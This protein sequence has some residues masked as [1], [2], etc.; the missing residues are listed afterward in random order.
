MLQMGWKFIL[1]ASMASIVRCSMNNLPQF[2]PDEKTIDCTDG[3]SVTQIC[4]IKFVIEPLTSMTYYKLS[5]DFRELRGYRATFSSAGKL[6][7]LRSGLD[8]TNLR[9]PILTDGHF[10]PIITINAQMPGP[11]IIAHEGQTLNITVYNELKNVE[12]VSIHWHGMHQRGTQGAD[13]VAYITQRPIP[14]HHKFTYTFKA[15]PAGTH[16]YHAHSGAQRTDGMYGALIVKDIIPNKYEHDLPDQHTLILMDWQKDAS[17]DLFYPIGTSLSYWKEPLHDQPYIRYNVTRGP[18]GTE[19]GQ[20]PFWSGIINDKGRHYDKDGNTFIK[21]T[22]LNYFNVSQGGRYRFRL[23]GA[24]A[25]YSYRFSIEGHNLT[26]I[27]TDGSPIKSIEDVDYVIVST[28]ER[29]DVVVNTDRIAPKDYWIW[30]ETLE[31]VTTSRSKGFHNP[32]SKHRAEAVLHYTEAS[33]TDIS[34]ITETRS[35]TQ[36]SR[37]RAVNCPFTQYSNIMECINV[38]QFE[39]LK[40]HTIPPSI[41]SPQKTLFYNFNFD[42]EIS[43]SGSSMDGINFRFPT[44]PPLTEYKDFKQSNSMC[45]RRGCDHTKL[46]HCACTHVIDINDLPRD[47]AVELVL[48]NRDVV[49]HADGSSHP[50]HLHGHY[51]YV[52]EVGYPVT[53]SNGH[54][55]ATSD[56]V[57]CIRKP[58]N[59]QCPTD[60]I[61]VEKEKRRKLKQVVQWRK[62]PEYL[63]NRSYAQKDTVFVPYGGYTVIRFTVDNPGWWF[64]HCHIEIHQLEGM[65]AVIK[66]LQGEIQK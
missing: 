19:V 59:N 38:E 36:S 17:I 43:T 24:Q 22:S 56:D 3:K 58:H 33:N 53:D 10:R 57:E 6:E 40:D 37:C 66:E 14:P 54:Y 39:S 64:F 62:A 61:T 26:V 12:G 46:S 4:D 45:P 65:A 5:R 25:L 28:G 51:F 41:F 30:A 44:Y 1:I 60:F 23:I 52:V 11:S 50:V 49:S 2:D 18:D 15:I 55:V 29:Y 20:T 9:P 8:V 48:A 31:D 7:L 42:G 32:I 34:M 47:S 27:A 13:G 21:H 35:C 16:W 63:N